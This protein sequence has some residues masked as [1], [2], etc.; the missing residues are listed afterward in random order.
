M[1]QTMITHFSEHERLL[2]V[3]GIEAVG[4]NDLG[5]VFP[6]DGVGRK[7]VHVHLDVGAHLPV[8]QELT[9]NDLEQQ[10]AF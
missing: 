9:G 6:S 3:D 4:G 8:G 5:A 7:P 10:A 1:R 2:V